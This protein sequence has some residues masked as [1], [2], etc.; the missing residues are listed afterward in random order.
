KNH[1]AKEI[2][3]DAPA[4]PQD[5][6]KQI[7]IQ[8]DAIAQNQIA[9]IEHDSKNAYVNALNRGQSVTSALGEADAAAEDTIDTVTGDASSVLMAAGINQGRNAVFSKSAKDIYALQRSEILDSRTCD[10][11]L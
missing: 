11:C 6:L 7:D 10:F 9:R 5:V 3:V 1:A 2:G 8:A 4:N